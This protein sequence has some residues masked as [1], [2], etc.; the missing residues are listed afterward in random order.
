M[1]QHALHQ[2][3]D[4][5]HQTH[6]AAHPAHRSGK[7]D[8][9][10]AQLIGSR[11]QTRRLLGSR[12]DLFQ[13]CEGS[14]QPRCQAIRQQA[15]GGVRFSAIPARYLRAHR[16]PARIGAVA[17]QRAS[18]TR[19]IR[20]PF[21]HRSSLASRHPSALTY[22][23]P[24]C[25]VWNRS[26]T[27]RGPAGGVPRGP[28]SPYRLILQGYPASGNRQVSSTVHGC[29]DLPTATRFLPSSQSF[30]RRPMRRLPGHS[31]ASAAFARI[32]S[33]TSMVL[34]QSRNGELVT[35]R[36]LLIESMNSRFL[37]RCPPYTKRWSLPATCR[38]S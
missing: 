29:L 17:R 22:C 9:V 31:P 33:A 26:C 20:T 13:F 24:V 12:Y 10:A 37:A 16:R 32:R 6:T 5:L 7:L 36:P 28:F 2:S 1:R 3:Q 19:V 21:G 34:M 8:G 18:A 23:S 14:W 11:H 35:S 15:E 25:N 4:V 38:V 30:R 27:D